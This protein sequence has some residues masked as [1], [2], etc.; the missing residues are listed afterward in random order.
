MHRLALVVGISPHI[1]FSPLQS[2]RLVVAQE[3]PQTWL[4]CVV[5]LAALGQLPWQTILCYLT[6][7]PAVFCH[8]QQLPSTE[9]RLVKTF[10]HFLDS[11]DPRVQKN[12]KTFSKVAIHP[13]SCWNR[14][15]F[16]ISD[17][18]LLVSWFDFASSSACKISLLLFPCSLL[19]PLK[20]G[21]TNVLSSRCSCTPTSSSST[22]HGMANG[23]DKWELQSSNTLRACLQMAIPAIV[24]LIQFTRSLL[25]PP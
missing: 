25:Q 17:G 4:F 24:L 22:Q 5:G 10:Q 12:R 15:E 20:A 13:R 2:K 9:S 18:K 11:Q 19:Y 21:V 6:R 14:R 1:T 16:V 7:A 8:Q 23:P 3:T